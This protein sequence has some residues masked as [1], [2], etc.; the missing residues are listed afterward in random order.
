MKSNRK[1]GNR[2]GET[3]SHPSFNNPHLHLDELIRWE[4]ACVKDTI[5]PLRTHKNCCLD[6]RKKNPNTSFLGNCS[7]LN[8]TQACCILENEEYYVNSNC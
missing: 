2:N 6:L 8:I 4:N 3:N 5:R 1:D 7:D